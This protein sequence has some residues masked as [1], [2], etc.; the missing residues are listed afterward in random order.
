MKRKGSLSH[1]LLRL[2][3]DDRTGSVTAEF[4]IALPILIWALVATVVFFDAFKSRYQTEMAANVVA[5]SLSRET[6]AFTPAFLEGINE[7]YDVLAQSKYPTRIRVSGI[8]WD[9]YMNRAHLSWSYGTRGLQPLP[10]DA[11]VMMRNNDTASMEAHFSGGGGALFNTSSSQMP[12]QNYL[13]SIPIIIPGETM[14]M[15]E[16]FGIW[17]PFA[18]VGVGTTRLSALVAVRPRFSPTVATQSIPIYLPPPSPTPIP[19]PTPLPTPTPIF[20]PSPT[21]APTPLPTPTPWWNWQATPTPG[22]T[23]TPWPTATPTPTPTPGPSPTPTPTPFPTPTPWPTPTPL[24]TP[25]PW[26]TPTP[27]PGESCGAYC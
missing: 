9:D 27:T 15:V 20:V 10:P 12:Q 5:D 16:T 18:S 26:P 14:M 2:V 7:A 24:P 6:Q 19:T 3:R 1:A 25:T 23:A 21:P 8:I 17:R 22:P 11:L 13:D 4:V